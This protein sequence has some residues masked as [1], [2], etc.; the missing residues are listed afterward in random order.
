MLDEMTAKLK[1]AGI[2]P[3]WIPV[4]IGGAIVLKLLFFGGVAFGTVK[5]VQSTGKLGQGL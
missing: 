3:V 2:S 4:L 1:A 5:G